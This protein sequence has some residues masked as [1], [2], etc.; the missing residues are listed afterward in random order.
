MVVSIDLTAIVFVF[1][2][3]NGHHKD[4]VAYFGGTD[5]YGELC[6]NFSVSSALFWWLTVLLEYL[7]LSLRV[8][9]FWIYLF[10]LTLVF[11]L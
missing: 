8:L 10:L 1:G 9:L 3:F 7:T 5:R 6:Y 11:V 2:N 4:W